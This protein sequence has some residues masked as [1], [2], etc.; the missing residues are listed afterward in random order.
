[1]FIEEI[2]LS[3]YKCSCLNVKRIIILYELGKT[4]INVSMKNHEGICPSIILNAKNQ[5]QSYQRDWTDCSTSICWESYGNELA[6]Y[7]FG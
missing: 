1:M 5:M 4:L 6:K 2:K 3:Q 7:Q